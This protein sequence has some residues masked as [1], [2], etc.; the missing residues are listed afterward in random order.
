MNPLASHGGNDSAPVSSQNVAM[1]G[2][3]GI[4][5]ISIHRRSQWFLK[6]TL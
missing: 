4:R 5:R 1:P 2:I 3:L 6:H